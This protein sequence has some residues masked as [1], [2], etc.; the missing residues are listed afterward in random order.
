MIK[1]FDIRKKFI[2]DNKNLFE[3]GIFINEYS[4]VGKN[5][6]DLCFYK[7][8]FYGYE[9]KSEADNLKRLLNQLKSY[10]RIFNYVYV[11]CHESHI[12]ELMEIVRKYNLKKLGIIEVDN[13]LNF[14]KIQEAHETDR[15]IRINYLLRNI[16]KD[17]LLEICENKEIYLKNKSK[18]YMINKLC[19]KLTL[20]EIEKYLYKNILYKYRNL[21]PKCKSN[22]IYNTS[23]IKNINKKIKNYNTKNSY[24]IKE[25]IKIQKLRFI[26]CFKCDYE[27]NIKIINEENKLIKT[28]YEE[29]DD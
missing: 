28:Y 9:I 6:V 1:D 8:K 20:D 12:N 18:N 15:S 13:K 7:N 3:S 19:G 25:Y 11:I 4:I 24:Q 27:F 21:C 22:L 5:V 26:K 2:L 29:I 10:F 16:S 23:G 14:K 17:N